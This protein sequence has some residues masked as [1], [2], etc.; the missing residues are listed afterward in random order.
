MHRLKI[1]DGKIVSA[2][3]EAENHISFVVEVQK[4]YR[5]GQIKLTVKVDKSY[6]L[7][8]MMNKD[9]SRHLIVFK[10]IRTGNTV[11]FT[12]LIDYSIYKY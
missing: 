2:P 12:S 10:G 4:V 9:L 5:C 11:S 6:S 7:F 8:D 3:V 1:Y